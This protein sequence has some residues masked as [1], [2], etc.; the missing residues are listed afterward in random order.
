MGALYFYEGWTGVRLPLPK[1]DLVAVLNRAL[2][3]LARFPMTLAL[4]QAHRAS[5]V[6]CVTCRRGKV[7]LAT[8]SLTH[9]ATLD[10]GSRQDWSHGKLGLAAVRRV[11]VLA[12]PRAVLVV[13]AL[14]PACPALAARRPAMQSCLSEMSVSIMNG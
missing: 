13:A 12:Q 10:A 11:P 4:E 14:A 1:F 7:V 6:W 9:R 8:E 5:D 3:A 2:A